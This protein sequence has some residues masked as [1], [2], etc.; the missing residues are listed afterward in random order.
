[1]SS[2]ILIY[3]V[4][5][6]LGFI[7][8]NMSLQDYALEAIKHYG[9]VGVFVVGFTQSIIQPVPVLPFMMMSQKLGLNPW[10]I[11]IVGVVSNMLGAMVSYW[12]GFFAGDRLVGKVLSKN[13]YIKAEALFNRYGT[14][15]IIIGEPYK[16]MCWVSG[17]LKFPFHRFIIATFI[18]RV[19][20]TL[21]YILIGH[22][23][24]KIF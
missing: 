8:E 18:S 22:F 19:I 1:M 5:G 10:I 21:I 6:L 24:Q 4:S 23:F 3:S 15:A 9:Y 2:S 16:V 14:F 11:G 7:I 17:I 20:H 13:H 12:L